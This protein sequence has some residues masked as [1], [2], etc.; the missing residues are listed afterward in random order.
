MGRKGQMPMT[1]DEAQKAC[2]EIMSLVGK[3]AGRKLFQVLEAVAQY[4]ANEH[5]A[6]RN[7]LEEL[8]IKIEECHNSP[9]YKAVWEIAQLRS[10]RPYSGPTYE[11]ELASAKA[12]LSHG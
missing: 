7:A 2:G 12:A 1:T 4:S 3:V 6:I 11:A 9:E 5:A 10:G 8:T